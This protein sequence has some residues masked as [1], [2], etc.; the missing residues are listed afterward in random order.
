MHDELSWN[1]VAM[2]ASTKMRE[3]NKTTTFVTAEDL[4]NNASLIDSMQRNGYKPVIVPL[5]LITKMEDYNKGVEEGETLTTA[6][7]YLIDEQKRFVPEVVDIQSL[8]LY[9]RKIYDKTVV[10]INWRKTKE[11]KGYT[12]SR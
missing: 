11:C 1:D 3:L 9:E 2:Y 6:R 4:K 7:Q 10:R 12:Y 5:N 8:S